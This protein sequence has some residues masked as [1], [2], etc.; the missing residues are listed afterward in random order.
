[1]RESLRRLA[2]DEGTSMVG[3]RRTGTGRVR[4]EL[5]NGEHITIDIERKASGADLLDKVCDTLDILE[6]DFFGL[7]HAQRG[8]PRVWV[9]LGRR[10]SKTFRNEPWDVRLAVKFYPPEPSELYDDITRYQLSLAVRRDLMEGRLICSQITYAL[11]ASYVLQAELGDKQGAVSTSTLC[12]HNAIPFHVLNERQQDNIEQLYAKHRGQTPADAELNY[13]E[14]AKRL[15]LYGA[16][17]H[18]AKDSED[19][20][21]NIAVSAAGITVLRDGVIM[22]RF[23]WTKILKISYNKR[24]YTLRLRPSEFD[25]FETHLTF[26]LPSSTASKR[27]WRCSVEHH[28]FFRREIPVKVERITGFP[29]LGSRR[30]SCRRTL[31]QMRSEIH[32]PALLPA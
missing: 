15:P 19:V 23:P 21:I 6:K 16:D 26:K 4:V 25:E 18:K 11:L 27:L 29:R 12:E 17:V 10:L 24:S 30:L 20:D 9:D 14:N 28:M 8:D 13:L 7:L 2:S 3:L 5:F 1:M 31:R 32:A 22:N